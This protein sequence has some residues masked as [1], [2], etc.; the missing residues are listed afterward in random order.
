MKTGVI[1]FSVAIC[2][3]SHLIAEPISPELMQ[4]V[5]A[6][7]AKG[8]GWLQKSQKENGAW[9]EAGM[10]A[11]TGLPLWALASSGIQQAKSR[12]RNLR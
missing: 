7:V 12:W 9:S 4:Q 11:L 5:K 6:S 8:A 10:P 3:A 1:H 2:M